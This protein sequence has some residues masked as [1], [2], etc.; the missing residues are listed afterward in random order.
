L[1]E[2]EERKQVFIEFS[3]IERTIFS[4]R[5]ILGDTERNK[6]NK[7][8]SSYKLELENGTLAEPRQ[9]YIDFQETMSQS[10]HNAVKEEQKKLLNYE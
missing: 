7:Q 6:L 10:I 8:L 1:K 4:C 2:L 5:S 3:E 9:K